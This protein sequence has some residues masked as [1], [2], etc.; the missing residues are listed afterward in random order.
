MMRKTLVMDPDTRQM[1]VRYTDLWNGHHEV[2]D[3][4]VTDRRDAGA[5]VRNRGDMDNLI[6]LPVLGTSPDLY[7]KPAPGGYITRIWTDQI[8]T[9]PTVKT[10]CPKAGNARRKCEAC[11]ALAA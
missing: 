9:G 6:G 3:Y 7:V 8:P 1:L 10:P 4:R 11:A 2:T 5:P